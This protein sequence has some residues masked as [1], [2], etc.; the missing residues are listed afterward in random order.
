MTKLLFTI[1]SLFLTF[2]A[3]AGGAKISELQ[4]EAKAD[5]DGKLYLEQ[6]HNLNAP[7]A[8]NPVSISEKSIVGGKSFRFEVNHG[9]CGQ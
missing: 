7:N 8:I 4:K 6:T 3:F 9:E 5:N 1:L 2:N